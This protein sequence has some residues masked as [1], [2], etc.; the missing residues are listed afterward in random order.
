MQTPA[1]CQV[2][3][4][5]IRSAQTYL[6]AFLNTALLLHM[7]MAA[8]GKRRVSQMTDGNTDEARGKQF[9][10]EVRADYSNI[11]SAALESWKQKGHSIGGSAVC[12]D[13]KI[14]ERTRGPDRHDMLHV[15]AALWVEGGPPQKM[16]LPSL[17]STHLKRRGIAYPWELFY[18]ASCLHAATAQ[19]SARSMKIKFVGIKYVDLQGNATGPATAIFKYE[20]IFVDEDENIPYSCTVRAENVLRGDALPDPINLFKPGRLFFSAAFFDTLGPELADMAQDAIWAKMDKEAQ[21]QEKERA[22]MEREDQFSMCQ[23]VDDPYFT[24]CLLMFGAFSEES[25][26]APKSLMKIQNEHCPFYTRLQMAIRK[27]YSGYYCRG[28][29]IVED[30]ELYFAI[31]TLTLGCLK[32]RRDAACALWDFRCR[33]AIKASEIADHEYIGEFFDVFFKFTNGAHVPPARVE[34]WLNRNSLESYRPDFERAVRKEY[35][36]WP[37]AYGVR[38]WEECA[39]PVFSCM[40]STCTDALYVAG[41]ERKEILEE[42]YTSADALSEAHRRQHT[43]NVKCKHLREAGASQAELRFVQKRAAMVN[44][45]SKGFQTSADWPDWLRAG[46]GIAPYSSSIR[47]RPPAYEEHVPACITDVALGICDMGSD[48][49]SDCAALDDAAADAG[50]DEE[51]SLNHGAVLLK[52]VPAC[53][54]KCRSLELRAFMAAAK[55]FCVENKP[56]WTDAFKILKKLLGTSL[57]ELDHLPQHVCPMIPVARMSHHCLCVLGH[58][59]LLDQARSS[60]NN[61]NTAPC[62]ASYKVLQ[63]FGGMFGCIVKGLDGGVLWR[64]Y[65]GPQDSKEMMTS[66]SLPCVATFDSVPEKAWALFE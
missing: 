2:G 30:Y 52:G 65:S 15:E 44:Q 20:E 6:E 63:P 11:L 19:S 40:F 51:K 25:F 32:E 59:R 46:G 3:V 27:E 57:T 60:Q 56:T 49:E 41:T 17:R 54:K 10:P 1:G 37:F 16:V 31:S 39:L 22:R 28:E 18:K 48:D 12:Y 8:T 7:A 23:N 66:A 34:A 45:I 35:G 36:E 58:R 5:I 64:G 38:C 43:L 14:V 4:A 61:A 53:F 62:A 29:N 47:Y 9:C 33:H 55:D 24:R 21:V 42:A 26:A 50:E 13:C